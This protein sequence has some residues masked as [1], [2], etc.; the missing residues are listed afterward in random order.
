MLPDILSVEGVQDPFSTQQR[1]YASI[2]RLLLVGAVGD[3][4]CGQLGWVT[5]TESP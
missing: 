3:E 2:G 4:L 5:A 1:P